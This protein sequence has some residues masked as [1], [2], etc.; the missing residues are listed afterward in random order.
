MPT[1]FRDFTRQILASPI[2]IVDDDEINRIF[3]E[4]TLRAR[5][6]TNLLCAVSAEDAFGKMEAFRPEMV[7]LD[8]LMPGGMDGFECCE[9]LRQQKR[10]CDL[11]ILIETTIT[12]PELRAKAFQKGATDFVSKP[13]YAEE[14][15]ARVR[16][17][18]EKRLSLKTLQRYKNRIEV[19]LESARQLQQGILPE[20]GDLKESERRCGLSVASAFEPSSEIGGD[21]W[22]M[23]NMFLHQTAL[24]LV[25]FSG[26]GVAA[27]LNAFRLHAYLKEYSQLAARPGEYLSYL[28]DKLLQLLP[29]GQF[30]TM[31]YGIVDTQTSQLFYACACM[32]HP[33]VLRRATG[34]AEMID[35]SGNPLGIGMHLYS[36][37]TIPFASGDLL[38]LYSDAYTETPDAKGA[39][40][41]EEQIMSLIEKNSLAS[42]SALKDIL[43]DHFKHHAGG[44]PC[45]DLTIVV[46]ARSTI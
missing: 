9:K 41:T 26:H 21:F 17:H 43:L 40:I 29:R 39:F 5:G 23:Q 27:A 32:P 10:Y 46:C 31:F 30:A 35:G 11:P 2:L 20:A 45:D 3:L 8:I 33:I 36:T 13:V 44:A 14:L 18:L 42:P 7:L 22:G 34:R 16:V 4:K 15:C 37:K 12:E 19:E 6:F 1:E 38:L 24:W 28:N 25:D